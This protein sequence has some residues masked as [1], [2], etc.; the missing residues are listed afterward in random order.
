MARGEVHVNEELDHPLPDAVFVI[1][2]GL[3]GAAHLDDAVAVAQ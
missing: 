3:A 1:D 2:G